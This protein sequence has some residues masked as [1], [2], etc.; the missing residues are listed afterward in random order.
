MINCVEK[1]ERLSQP[2]QCPD[3]VYEI[4]Q[5]CWSYAPEDR[6]TFQELLDKFSSDP[7][8]ANIKEL[9]TAVSIS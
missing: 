5:K 4:M 2:K 7:D 3:H 9:I 8:Y 6:P 1:G